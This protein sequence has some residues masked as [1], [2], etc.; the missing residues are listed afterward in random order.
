MLGL[1]TGQPV[2]V[3]YDTRTRSIRI[4]PSVVS[5]AVCA[6]NLKSYTGLYGLCPECQRRLKVC[7][8]KGLTLD[9]AYK[10]LKDETVD[11]SYYYK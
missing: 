4:T 9:A 8:S 2:S 3:T 10:Q 7:L 11:E 6:Q 1:V 5:C